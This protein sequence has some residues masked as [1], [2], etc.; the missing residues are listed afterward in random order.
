MLTEDSNKRFL[1]D[2]FG[3]DPVVIDILK[4]ESS[5]I[6]VRQVWR[7]SFKLT[8]TLPWQ[9]YITLS[10]GDLASV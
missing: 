1:A 3:A 10:C 6:P 9:H 2:S 5:T 8:I 7:V 4:M